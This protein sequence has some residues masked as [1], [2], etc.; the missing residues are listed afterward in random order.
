[1]HFC[2]RGVGCNV[3]HGG[4]HFVAEV[5]DGWHRFGKSVSFPG[6]NLINRNRVMTVIGNKRNTS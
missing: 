5:E 6:E 4:T 1:M 2:E 3:R